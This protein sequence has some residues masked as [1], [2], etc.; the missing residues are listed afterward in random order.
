M[1]CIITDKGPHS[2]GHC[3]QLSMGWCWGGLL[4]QIIDR[5]QI[6][7]NHKATMVLEKQQQFEV[8]RIEI[9][10]KE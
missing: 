7:L 9:L 2:K 1:A 3:I 6:Y 8:F 5:K 10:R 4:I